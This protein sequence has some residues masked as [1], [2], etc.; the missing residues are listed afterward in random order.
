SFRTLSTSPGRGPKARRLRTCSA[1]WRSVRFVSV[2]VA[3]ARKRNATTGRRSR[4]I[5]SWTD[6]EI[7]RL[8]PGNE[9]IVP[10][11]VHRLGLKS[12]VASDHV[13]SHDLIRGAV[14]GQCSLLH[15]QHS[16]A[17]R[18]GPIEIVRVIEHR[19]T[20]TLHDLD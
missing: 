16:I 12:E 14:D 4:L 6:C 9:P 13:G 8:H 1:R 2:L 20:G 10:A 11:G 3:P 5:N 18:R 19:G 7:E 17:V 15:H